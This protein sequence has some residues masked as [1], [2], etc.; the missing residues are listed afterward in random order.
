MLVERSE[1]Q[2]NPTKAQS[3]FQYRTYISKGGKNYGLH[4]TEDFLASGVSILFS[5]RFFDEDIKQFF[6]F[7]PS[8]RTW[9]QSMTLKL[10]LLRYTIQTLTLILPRSRTGKVWF[11]T[12]TSNKRAARPKLYTKSLARDLKRMYSRLTLVRIYINLNSSQLNMFREILLP[13]FRSTRLCVT[14]C[15]VMHTPRCC[16]PSAGN[17]VEC[18]LHHKL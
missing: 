2:P 16:R 10:M 3:R 9:K 8:Q 15:G 6:F 12:S 11:Y 17:I 5:K 4:K 13:I 18:A 7:S 1:F 14:A